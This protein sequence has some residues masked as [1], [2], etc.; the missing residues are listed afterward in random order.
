[1]ATITATESY[2]NDRKFKNVGNDVYEIKVPGVRLYCFKDQIDG[3]SSK[4]IIATNGG[5]KNNKKEQ[6]ADIKRAL[7]IKDRYFTAKNSADTTLNY[8]SK[9]HEN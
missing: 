7:Q 8:I 3:L 2:H 5:S 4:L 9:S 6:T 1:M